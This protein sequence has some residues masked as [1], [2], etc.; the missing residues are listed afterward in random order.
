[1]GRNRSR[2]TSDAGMRTR[3]DSCR[4][5]VNFDPG[6]AFAVPRTPRTLPA[7][8]PPFAPV[9]RHSSVFSSI[10]CSFH[11]LLCKYAPHLIDIIFGCTGWYTLWKIPGTA[12][13]RLKETLDVSACHTWRTSPRISPERVRATAPI[14]RFEHYDEWNALG[15]A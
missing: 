6:A 1:M 9:L 10:L 5:S 14:H 12:S 3:P 11:R 7:T 4:L 13:S 2:S 15:N 8:L